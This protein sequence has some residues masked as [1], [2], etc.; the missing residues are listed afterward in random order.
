M[1]ETHQDKNKRIVKNSLYLYARMFIML[2]LSIFTA[3]VV[4]NT[5]GVDNYGI[6]HLV[7]G[8]IVFFSFLNRGLARASSRFITA[9]I[10]DNDIEKGTRTFNVCLQAHLIIAAIILLLAETVGL[11]IVNFILNIPADRMYA[12]NWVYQLSVFSAVLGIIQSPFGSVITAY[13]KMNIYA[14]FT[15]LDVIF[16]LFVIYAV[17]AINGDKLIVYALLIFGVGITN[18][19]I[20]RTYSFKT[21]KICR[22]KF[23][24]NVTLLKEIFKFTSW[25]LFGQACVVGTNQGVGVLI[26]IYHSVSVNAAMSVSGNITGVVNQFVH[27]FRVAFNPQ[28]IKS[29]NLKDYTYVNSLVVRSSKISSFLLIIFFVPL[30][31]ETSNVLR[32][33]LGD[34][35]KYAV[36]FCI[37]GLC[38]SYIETICNP[39]WTVVYSQTNIKKYQ[40]YISSVYSL[41]FIIGWIILFLG[42][43]PYFVIAVRLVIFL[44]L[45]LIRLK[46]VVVFLPS[47]NVKDWLKEV[48]AN[49]L[50]IF[51][52]SIAIIGFVN[53]FNT[54][55]LFLHILAT[56]ILSLCLTLPLIYFKGMSNSERTFIITQI[57]KR[58]QK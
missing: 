50:F 47:F 57:K 18:M 32:L 46:F 34:Y 22:L 58:I 3:R 52:A 24:K 38:C 36:E 10:A 40:L 31:F 56:T 19:I 20:Y 43:A 54:L 11:Y 9:D 48:F 30:L 14:Y 29:Y 55:P 33:W 37:L 2:A 51:I 39:L 13:E 8:I 41:N 49:G 1:S 26:N 35:P 15:I 17:Q 4:Y 5:L 23:V 25:S 27:N 12:A 42:A 53:R 28:I 7:G 21:F 44:G 6:Y 45:M 16:K